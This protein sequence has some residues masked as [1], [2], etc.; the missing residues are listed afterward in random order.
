MRCFQT[1]GG[2]G[3]GI[4]LGGWT[5][6]RFS[7]AFT[8]F[9][10]GLNRLEDPMTRCQRTIFRVISLCEGAFVISDC[11]VGRSGVGPRG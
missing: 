10:R 5:G 2:L 6:D 4:G 9:D 1:P 11:Y 8:R 7:D 3:A